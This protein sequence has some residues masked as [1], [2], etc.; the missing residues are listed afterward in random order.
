MTANQVST[1]TSSYLFCME[2]V[3]D[4][5]SVFEHDY[6]RFYTKG[7]PSPLKFLRKIIA[8]ESGWWGSREKGECATEHKIWRA[9]RGES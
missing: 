8:F 2:I 4:S 3:N 7:T 5:S 6:T 9:E 1:C